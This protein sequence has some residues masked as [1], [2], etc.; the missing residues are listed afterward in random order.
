MRQF[1]QA[2]AANTKFAQI[3]VRAAAELA[4]I[5]SAYRKLGLTFLFFDQ[6]LLCQS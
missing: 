2:D 4:T 5:V 1:T 3:A 6:A